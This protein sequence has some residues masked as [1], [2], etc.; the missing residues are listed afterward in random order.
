MRKE[1]EGF[2]LIELI[3]VIAVIGVVASMAVGNFSG[4]RNRAQI[5]VAKGMAAI[6]MN[7]LEMYSNE[8][9]AKQGITPFIYPSQGEMEGFGGGKSELYKTLS[10]YLATDPITIFS[11]E[12]ENDWI[13]Y[14]ISGSPPYTS[15][16]FIVR[17]RD[18]ERTPVTAIRQTTALSPYTDLRRISG[19]YRG[20]EVPYP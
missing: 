1:R 12:N 5:R 6:I 3:V 11:Y 8:N 17:A 18:S 13:K 14:L 10:P 20:E 15:Y 7:A 4:M 19:K 9:L 2:S 16:T